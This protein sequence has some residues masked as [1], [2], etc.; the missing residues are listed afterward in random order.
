MS[1]HRRRLDKVVHERVDALRA[2]VAEQLD[3]RRGQ[4]LRRKQPAADRIVDVVVDVGDAVDDPHDPALE[5]LRLVRPRALED[6][7]AHLPGEVH[8][9]PIALEHVDDPQRVLVVAE[10][11][12]EPLAQQA[13]ECLLPR[14]AEGRVAEVVP[15][16]DRLDEILVQPQ[17]PAHPARDP[18]RLERVREPRANVVA[19]GRDEDLRLVLEPAER[20]GMDDAVAVV[21]ERCSAGRSRAPAAHGRAPR[22]TGLPAATARSP[23][24]P[25]CAPRSLRQ[26]W[27]PDSGTLPTVVGRPVSPGRAMWGRRDPA[28][29][30]R[31]VWQ[32]HR[33][34]RR[35]AAG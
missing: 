6:P 11:E 12:T 13:V 9:A 26:P 29:C 4:I 19:D 34:P 24:A 3:L 7:V 16:P 14:V 10:A 5:R 1:P 35:A 30:G 31:N 15:E 17:R 23:P 25:G 28:N 2:R 32:G 21:L 22:R 20:L 33:G 27:G 8:S 18:G